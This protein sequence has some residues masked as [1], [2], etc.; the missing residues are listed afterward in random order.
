M[1]Y[2]DCENKHFLTKGLWNTHDVCHLTLFDHD[3]TEV[4]I[5]DP[6]MRQTESANVASTS[7]TYVSSSS[8]YGDLCSDDALD[9]YSVDKTTWGK[10]AFDFCENNDVLDEDARDVESS[11]ISRGRKALHFLGWDNEATNTDG[12]TQIFTYAYHSG[13]PEPLQTWS[14][15][16]QNDRDVLCTATHLDESWTPVSNVLAYDGL[17]DLSRADCWRERAQQLVVDDEFGPSTCKIST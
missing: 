10:F 8:C 4:Q 3:N 13:Q 17:A 5:T 14:L 12:P 6:R 9:E 1:I 16:N 15:Y 2:A 7:S 11:G